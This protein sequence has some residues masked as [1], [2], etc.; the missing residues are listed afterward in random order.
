MVLA[1]EADRSMGVRFGGNLWP[2]GGPGLGAPPLG[3]ADVSACT[4]ALE[5]QG[6]RRK[7][8]AKH[9]VAVYLRF[10]HGDRVGDDLVTNPVTNLARQYG[11]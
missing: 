6:Y 9:L 4:E 11:I 2:R 5:T 8:S 3:N 7:L 10:V 1:G